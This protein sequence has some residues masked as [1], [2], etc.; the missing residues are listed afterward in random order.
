MNRGTFGFAYLFKIRP[1]HVVSYELEYQEFYT[2][3]LK[4]FT[5]RHSIPTH[6]ILVFA[7]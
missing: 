1:G 3:F 5:T 4:D 2:V 6:A 7:P